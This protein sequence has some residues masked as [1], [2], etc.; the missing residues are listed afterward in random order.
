M[1]AIITDSNVAPLHAE[2]VRK[3]MN[4]TRRTELFVIAAGE[5]SKTRREWAL[6]TDAMIARGLGRDALVLALGG[7]VVGDLAGFVA[8]TFARGLPYV[9]VPTSLLAMVDASIGGK[10]GVDTP[11]GK[12]LVGVFHWP[13]LVVVDPA[14][15][16]TLPM[17]H[18]RAGF[19][20]VLKHGAIAS[21]AHFQR[22]AALAPSLPDVSASDMEALIADSI[23]IKARIVAG[24]ER[25]AG[26][27]R[28]LNAGHTL[29]HALERVSDYE[30]PHGEAVAIGLLLEAELGERLSVTAPGTAAQLRAVLE[31]CRLPVAIPAGL[32]AS[33]I[34]AATRADKKSRDGRVEYAL[35]ARLGA[36]DEADGRFSRAVPDSDVARILETFSADRLTGIWP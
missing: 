2:R 5:A 33:D 7:G 15:L 28:W 35:L 22:A 27:R 32:R 9:Q 31:K 20:E 24:D 3:A 29:A 4:G 14:F 34:L 18:W 11:A 17:P 21:E 19:A 12:N 13:Q 26:P 23:R 1:V 25:E 10:T 36:A 8:A 6:V 16:T 30:M